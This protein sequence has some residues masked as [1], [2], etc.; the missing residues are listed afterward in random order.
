[1]LVGIG[2]G[3]GEEPLPLTV[4][5]LIVAQS[6]QLAVQVGNGGRLLMNLQILIAL[7]GKQRDKL[8]LQC[9]LALVAV[10]EIL[11]RLVGSDH[12]VFCCGGDDVKKLIDS[13]ISPLIFALMV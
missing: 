11:H 4:G 5:E 10:R 2:D 3:V 8:S 1:M 12:G 7:M 13:K 6:F 9:R